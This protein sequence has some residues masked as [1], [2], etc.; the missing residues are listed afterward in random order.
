MTRKC[1][2]VPLGRCFDGLETGK[3]NVRLAFGQVEGILPALLPAFAFLRRSWRAIDWRQ[4]HSVA[5]LQAGWR[6]QLVSLA[7]RLANIEARRAMP[8]IPVKVG[9]DSA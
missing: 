3:V 9:V 4:S 7:D 6:A 1:K 2:R 5:W 8:A